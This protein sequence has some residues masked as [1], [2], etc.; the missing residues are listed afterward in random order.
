[1]EDLKSARQS[2]KHMDEALGDIYQELSD[3]RG[4]SLSEGKRI[5]E[6]FKTRL[7]DLVDIKKESEG[8]NVSEQANQIGIYS[9]ELSSL[10]CGRR[11]PSAQIL[12]RLAN[13]YQTSADYLLGIAPYDVAEGEEIQVLG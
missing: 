7:S 3:R 1:M 9:T 13:Y 11:L 4:V 5:R 10:R 12:V 2:E 8:I 6:I